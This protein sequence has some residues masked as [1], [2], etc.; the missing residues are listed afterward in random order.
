MFWGEE[1]KT[2]VNQTNKITQTKQNKTYKQT[3]PTKPKN[4]PG[5]REL[6]SSLNG[7]TLRYFLV[8]FYITFEAAFSGI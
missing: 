3:K 2:Q 5:D 6:G 4:I 1:I 8:H 7:I